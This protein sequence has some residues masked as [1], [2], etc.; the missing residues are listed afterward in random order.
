[1]AA[2]IP[3]EPDVIKVLVVDDS[4]LVRQLITRIL[5]REEDIEV[6]GTAGDALAAQEMI[7]ITKPDVL[8]LD[9]E[10]PG[11]D[12]LDFLERLMRLMPMPVVMVSSYTERGAEVTLRALELGAVDFVAKPA[13]GGGGR[14]G[15]QR[16]A[17]E[18]VANIRAAAKSRV[19]QRSAPARRP[20]PPASISGA[21][22]KLILIGASTGG[23]EAIRQ[24]LVD[25][26]PLAPPILITQHMPPGFTASFAKRLDELCQITVREARDGE[27][28]LPG[29]AYVAPGDYHLALRREG[30]GFGIEVNQAARCNMHRPSVDVLFNSAVPHVGR[31]AVAVLLTGMGKD[32][33]LGMKALH[34]AGVH[35]VAQ[36]EASCVVYG[37]PREAVQLGAA[38]EVLDVAA[39]TPHLLAHFGAR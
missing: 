9:V 12:G 16:F 38:D 39:I 37:M 8:T 33:A 13:A 14:E 11:M 36:S 21:D 22:G 6:V 26:P 34:D 17:S 4:A 30:N 35:T 5:V 29:H 2:R 1:M 7:R 24:M 10:M 15:L 23:T 32:G 28:A 3:R 25:M 27:P 31:N 20:R 18:L 19:G